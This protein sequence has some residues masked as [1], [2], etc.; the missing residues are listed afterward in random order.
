[1]T[2]PMIE[3][4]HNEPLVLR[5]S[6]AVVK[7]Q[8]IAATAVVWGLNFILLTAR[9]IIEAGPSWPSLIPARL[10]LTS[11]GIFLCFLMHL[12]LVRCQHD[13]RRQSIAA[14]LM[15]PAATE[16]YA[17]TSVA[18]AHY[19]HGAPVPAFDG[20]ALLQLVSILWLFA[21]WCGLY[22]S[23][24]YGGRLRAEERR[25]HA[26]RLLAKTAQLQALRYQVNPHFLFNTLNSIS[27]LIADD[28]REA[29]ERMVES[30]S[31]FLRTTLQVNDEEEVPLSEE[32]DLQ[33]AYLDVEQARFPDLDLS[34]NVAK[35]AGSA[36]VPSLILQPLVENAVKHGI[37]TRPGRGAITITADC[38][39]TAVR[40]CV[41]NDTSL[42]S[43][44]A[45]PG[46]GLLNVQRRLAAR[47]G[48]AAQLS[49]RLL[50]SC[51]FEASIQ[52]PL[53]LAS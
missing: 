53:R 35:G 24:S 23:I 37:A 12:V 8:L 7:W 47:Y 39:A 17:W 3:T 13:M 22:L 31:R 44:A 18:L 21:T 2:W 14:M 6:P 20:Q 28:R 10:L 29:A 34:I 11:T 1:M 38:D 32:L 19:L 42:R 36:L 52:I 30:L 15:L 16:L 27:A 50:E 9:S 49:T 33:R 48:S 46:I 25:S 41:S 45:S 51:R 4:S 43:T 5:E 40:V 26:D